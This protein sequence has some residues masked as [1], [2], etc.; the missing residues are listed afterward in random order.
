MSE[1]FEELLQKAQEL[2]KRAHELREKEKPEA[3]ARIKAEI[4]KY[5]L[6]AEDLGFT[7]ANSGKSGKAA[8]S[9]KSASGT[10]GKPQYRHPKSDQTWTGR[11]QP[12]SWI[13]D[14]PDREVFRIKE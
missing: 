12:P 1:N 13:K 10:V 14:A 3:I 9:A 4:A 7:V 5:E 8:A 6:S 11:G 2:T